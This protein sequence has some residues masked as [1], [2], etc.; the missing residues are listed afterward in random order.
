MCTSCREMFPGWEKETEIKMTENANET[1]KVNVNGD[2]TSKPAT[3][4]LANSKGQMYLKGRRKNNKTKYMQRSLV[5]LSHWLIA[6]MLTFT[7]MTRVQ[8][9]WETF[10]VK[11]ET[12]VLHQ[13]I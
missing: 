6:L 9:D 8:C 12:I 5:R 7:I 1:Q 4:A 11:K 2:E 13:I 10:A 3:E